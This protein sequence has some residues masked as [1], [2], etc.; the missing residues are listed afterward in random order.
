MYGLLEKMMKCI[1]NV[2]E[3]SKK[4]HKMFEFHGYEMPCF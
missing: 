4:N 2:F 1:E 3:L